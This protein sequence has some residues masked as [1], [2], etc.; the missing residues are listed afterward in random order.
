MALQLESDQKIRIPVPDS[1]P[2]NN[3]ARLYKKSCLSYRV[4][5]RLD[6]R[7]TPASCPQKK[8]FDQLLATIVVRAA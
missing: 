1:R 8:H 6:E 4:G 5:L 7:L 3:P 2:L